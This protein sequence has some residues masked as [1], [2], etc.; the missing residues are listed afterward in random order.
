MWELDMYAR[1]GF[2][3]RV[4]EINGSPTPIGICGM[5]K[6]PYLDDPDIGFALLPEYCGR[7]YAFEAAQGVLSNARTTLGLSRIVATTRPD[8][9]RSASLLRKLGLTFK[10][11]FLHPDGDRSLDLYKTEPD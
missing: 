11:Q 8:N 6:R 4:I 1:L 5:A 10:M 3:F 2:G 7:G 9:Q